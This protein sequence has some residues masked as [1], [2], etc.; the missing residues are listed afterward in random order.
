M[1]DDLP[2]R[3]VVTMIVA[4]I[5]VLVA[6]VPDLLRLV[7]DGWEAA[8]RTYTQIPPKG[9]IETSQHHIY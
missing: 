7:E 4:L 2:Q 1:D 9:L 5:S 6:M 3:T 8:E